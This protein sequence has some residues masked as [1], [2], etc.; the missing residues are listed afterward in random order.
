MET[1]NQSDSLVYTPAECTKLLKCSRHTIY[2]AV[3][4]NRIPHI[5]LGRK[6]L[7]PRASLHSWLESGGTING[8]NNASTNKG[9]KT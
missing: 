4:R 5:H 8:E 2:E 1:D 7:I 9:V 3:H 6:L